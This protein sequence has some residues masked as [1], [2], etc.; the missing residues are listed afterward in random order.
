MSELVKVAMDA[1]VKARP[2]KGSGGDSASVREY[3]GHIKAL[4]PGEAAFI[5]PG[6]KE[7][8]LDHP[9]RA[10]ALRLHAA[11]KRAGKN[12][13]TV[14]GEHDGKPGVYVTLTDAPVRTR[15][16]AAKPAADAAT[17]PAAATPGAAPAN[18]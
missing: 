5:L 1:L 8:K 15:K 6:D 17:K 12:V 4:K 11:A 10:I 2:A 7:K 18:A 14:A 3:D 16:T 9:G 13:E